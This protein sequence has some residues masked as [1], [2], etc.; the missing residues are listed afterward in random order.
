MKKILP[1]R[2]PNGIIK[3]EKEKTNEKDERH[4]RQKS[5]GGYIYLSIDR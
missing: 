3:I 5:R 4:T 2:L 1:A